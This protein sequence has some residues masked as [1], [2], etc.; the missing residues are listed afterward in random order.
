M[1]PFSDFWRSHFRAQ[2]PTFRFFAHHLLGAPFWA[3]FPLPFGLFFHSFTFSF[4]FLRQKPAFLVFPTMRPFSD[5]W[6]SHFRAQIP[7]FRF[8]PHHLYKA[9]FWAPFP[10][11]F[12]L[13]FHS[14][15]FSLI[16]LRRN[17]A[18]LVSPTMRP[19]S[20]FW[21]SHFRADFPTFSLVFPHFPIVPF[22]LLFLPFCCLFSSP[23][24]GEFLA[25]FG[26]FYPISD[27]KIPIF[28]APPSDPIFPSFPHFWKFRFCHQFPNFQLFSPIFFPGFFFGVFLAT[29][30]F[31]FLSQPKFP[32]FSHLPTLG[33][34]SH[35]SRPQIWGQIPDFYLF[36]A[37]FL[38]RLLLGHFPHFSF[39]SP[40]F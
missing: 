38:K 9:P 28:G 15:T 3:P 16:F 19:F 24:L 34:F 5:F 25:L 14:F 36:L 7:T 31:Y 11:P 10:L 39:F 20:D 23:F 27:T 37:H 30:P 2:I 40:F 29:F 35:F 13:F 8:F 6:R 12:G 4:V 33:P 21:R 22:G 18:F 17:P 32:F 1:R 26:A